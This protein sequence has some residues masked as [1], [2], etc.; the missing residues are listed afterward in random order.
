MEIRAAAGKNKVLT[1]APIFPLEGNAEV[2]EEFSTGSFA[3]RIAPLLPG[4]ERK[5]L[6][7]VSKEDLSDFLKTKPPKAIL[8][9][10]EGS[11]ES[12]LLSYAREKGYKA[13]ELSNG[14]T[15]WLSS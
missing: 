7:I 9:G 5:E 13:V 8:V 10:S 2:Y 12:P 14:M 4:N 1:L 15:L 11:L 6:G 3:W